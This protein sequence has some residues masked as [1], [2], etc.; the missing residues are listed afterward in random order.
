[1]PRASL[2]TNNRLTG[3]YKGLDHHYQDYINAHPEATLDQ[4]HR[5]LTDGMYYYL[6]QLCKLDSVD[7]DTLSEEE[8]QK[9]YAVVKTYLSASPLFLL[10]S[11]YSF[12]RM[13]AAGT[14]AVFTCH[15]HHYSSCNDDWFFHFWL[16]QLDSTASMSGDSLAQLALVL[17]LAIAIVLAAIALHYLINEVFDSIE[18]FYYNEGMLQAILSFFNVFANI[19]VAALLADAY[20]TA[21]LAS[22]ALAAG[23]ANPI[24]VAT[25][26][27]FCLAY[28]GAALGNFVSNKLIQS[29]T[30]PTTS[31]ALYRKDPHRFTLTLAE[32]GALLAKNIDPIKV[33]CA[34]IALRENMG[35]EAAST[36]W[37]SR[38]RAAGRDLGFIRQLR[39]GEKVFVEVG[40]MKFD[41]RCDEVILKNQA[42]PTVI[43]SAPPA[44]EDDVSCG[45]RFA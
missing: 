15:H 3:L 7:F 25:F 43:A 27:V 30:A 16:F 45:S 19:A 42:S 35:D 1:M 38:T 23:V 13:P 5:E 8:K 12:S 17:L 33:K 4:L 10:G 32:E 31:Q 37:S 18:R 40:G 20:A 29:A 28:V 2:L 6:D 9:A 24:G 34:I 21:P 39:R 44:N 41:C 22:L 14:N 36:F 11:P 26:G